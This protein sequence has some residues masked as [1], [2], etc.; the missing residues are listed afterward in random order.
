MAVV[1]FKCPIDEVT[2][3]SI[4]ELRHLRLEV[5]KKQIKDID[6]VVATLVN[7]GAFLEEEKEPYRDVIL[8]D[9]TDKCY[10]L[11]ERM[12]VRETVYFDEIELYL[13][14]LNER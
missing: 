14:V 13:D 9:L 6:K 11:E 7:E 5:L 2:L 3:S 12:Q 10:E 1:V 4:N 8:R